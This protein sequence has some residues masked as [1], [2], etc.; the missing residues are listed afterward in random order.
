M[1]RNINKNSGNMSGKSPRKNPKKEEKTL[2]RDSFMKSMKKPHAVRNP[3]KN[4]YK[5]DA[6]EEDEDDFYQEADDSRRNF[7]KNSR[8]FGGSSGKISVKTSE[9]FSRKQA[10]SKRKEKSSTEVLRGTQKSSGTRKSG[11]RKTTSST[12]SDVSSQKI[13]KSRNTS[14]KSSAD[15]KE[16]L[17]DPAVHGERIQ[18]ILAQAG[19]GSRRDCEE[20]ILAGRIMIDRE[21]IDELGTRVLPHQTIHVDGELLRRGQKRYYFALNKPTNVICTNHD[22]SGRRRALDFIRENIPGLF[23]VGRL[24]LHS[25]GLLLITNDGELANRLTHP[26]Y[27]VPKVYQVRVSGTPTREEMIKIS[28]GVYLAEG[29]A[30]AE[31]VKILHQYK[32]GTS[33]LK[34]TLREGRNR[35][36]RRIL[37]KVG[38][39]V[40]TLER[41]SIG[42]LKLGKLPSGDYRPLTH[43]E[44]FQLKKLVGLN[45]KT[46]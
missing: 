41:V 40:L 22:P 7:R 23:P 34:I 4:L 42:P 28:R 30:K 37:A 44:I 29:V 5:M 13:K 33:M 15:P 18:K 21:V 9:T 27:E 8:V 6:E 3:F 1:R 19:F 20:L 43:N 38:H 26:R 12:F 17:R 36:I 35:E 31:E 10:P 11:T 14:K 32:D 46:K 24:D 16:V 39:N 25:K 2:N 45:E